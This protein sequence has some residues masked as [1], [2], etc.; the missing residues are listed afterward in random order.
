MKVQRWAASVAAATVIV[1]GGLTVASV[2]LPN[3]VGAQP[4]PV[5]TIE[6]PSATSPEWS[7]A[8]EP[9]QKALA[10]LVADGT[11]TQAQ[12]DSV[13]SAYDSELSA[14]VEAIK[15]QLGEV[16]DQV[17]TALATALDATPAEVETA[18]T[19]GQSIGD[20]IADKGLDRQDVVDGLVAALS[21]HIDEAAAGGEV[22]APLVAMVQSHLAEVVDKAIDVK[23][24][25][26]A[27]AALQGGG[28]L[29]GLLEGMSG[30]R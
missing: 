7:S 13:T 22:P 12:A 23:V 19:S 2:G 6:A 15:A 3:L 8:D 18:L 1:G 14:T 25:L 10:G 4:N 24:P 29:S 27:L 20:V 9:L 5:T 11:L 30:G 26:A 21:T 28:D 17:L 16:K